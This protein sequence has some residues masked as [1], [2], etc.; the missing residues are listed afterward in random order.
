MR[1]CAGGG[2]LVPH[3]FPN[4]AINLSLDGG[5]AWHAGTSIDCPLEAAGKFVVVAPDV[6]LFICRDDGQQRMRAPH[7]PVTPQ[8]LVKLAGNQRAESHPPPIRPDTGRSRAWSRREG[9]KLRGDA[10]PPA[11]LSRPRSGSRRGWPP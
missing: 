5:H 11:P 9:D 2:L 6:L 1:C 4:H 7:L 8:G 10:I 3:R